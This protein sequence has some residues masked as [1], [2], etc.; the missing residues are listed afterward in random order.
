M[1]ER[2]L[3]ATTRCGHTKV[4]LLRCGVGIDICWHGPI[5]MNTRN[6]T[7]KQPSSQAKL[8]DSKPN[9]SSYTNPSTYLTSHQ[10][11]K[12]KG[13][14][15]ETNTQ[16]NTQTSSQHPTINRTNKQTKKQRKTRTNDDPGPGVVGHSSSRSGRRRYLRS[17][18]AAAGRRAGDGRGQGPCNRKVWAGGGGRPVGKG[19]GGWGLGE[20]LIRCFCPFET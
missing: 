20:V 12:I 11:Y 7:N 4:L 9:S 19:V 14:N 1:L 6:Q 18:A 16:T 17:A 15:K 3:Y 8:T 5:L 2:P 13:R 10:V